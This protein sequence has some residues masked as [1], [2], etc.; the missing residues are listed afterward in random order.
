MK[1]LLV[2]LFLP[3]ALLG[4]IPQN[5]QKTSGTLSNGGFHVPTGATVDATGSGV[6]TATA[7]PRTGI[8]GL[9]TG[10]ATAL[11]VN[12]GTAGSPVVNG[13]ALGTPASGTATNLTGLPLTSGVTGTLPV[14]NGGTGATSFTANAIIKG[15]G[16]S[17]QQVANLT[18]TTTS[19]VTTVSGTTGNEVKVAT[20]AGS[21]KPVTVAPDGTGALNLAQGF[22]VEWTGTPVYPI[23]ITG[24]TQITQVPVSS[25]TRATYALIP[26]AGTTNINYTENISA[27]AP[28]FYSAIGRGLVTIKFWNLVQAGNFSIG[29]GS[30]MTSIS[31]PSLS[32]CQDFSIS[33]SDSITTV[34]FPTLSFISGNFASG[35]MP[36]LTTFSLPELLYTK[37]NFQPTAMAALTTFSY[38]KFIAAGAN[39]QPNTMASLTTLSFPEF[40]Y[41]VVN[42]APNTMASLTTFSFPKF[43]GCQGNFNPNTMA[44]LTSISMPSMTYL[45]GTFQV[46]AMAS[47]TTL[48]FPAM[49]T[50]NSTIT[51][52]T[53]LGA[54]STVTLGTIGTLKAVNGAT[55]TFSGQALN[56]ASVDGIL[57]LL[58]SLDGTG[59]TTS[60]GTGKTVT[61]NGG[62]NASPTTSGTS[63]TTPA[64]SS[65]VGVGTTCTATIV[66]HGFSTGDYITVTGVTTLTNAN[67]TAAT[68]T[69]SDADHFTFTIVSQSAT[70]AGTATL[71]R[72]AAAGTDGFHACQVLRVRGATVTTA[73]GF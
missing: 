59:G 54:V 14:G 38:P 48:S 24:V 15:N 51:A 73:L 22:D 63:T 71:R 2:L 4:Q 10:V 12:V 49:V 33:S 3:L 5:V 6:I 7:V 52:T 32:V 34:D 13:G 23:M 41:C 1:K 64:G 62:T 21:N 31:A 55:V 56:Q 72:T 61:L 40:L 60:F 27:V 19:N 45:G 28:G 68:I 36:A 66:A 37:Q 69:V 18:E 46:N 17:A 42:F 50:Y 25:G 58:A 29:G 9:G 39:F 67:V 11:G 47:L 53:G 35:T 57:K 65:F 43:I 30:L 44:A 26:G 70:G 16:S 8:S 20:F